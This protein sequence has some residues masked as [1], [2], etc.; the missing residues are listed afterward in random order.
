MAWDPNQPPHGFPLVSAPIRA[1]FQALDALMGPD[2]A[3]FPIRAPDGTA[4]APSYSFAS[5]P[6]TGL[7]YTNP[8]FPN[9]S[10]RNPTGGEAM[11]YGEPGTVTEL[12]INGPG[13]GGVGLSPVGVFLGTWDIVGEE[14]AYVGADSSRPLALYAGG[15]N[16]R[17]ETTGAFQPDTDNAFDLGDAT[18]RVRDLHLGRD[19]HLS[20]GAIPT[21]VAGKATLTFAT[22]PAWGTGVVVQGPDGGSARIFSSPGATE[23]ALVTN[24]GSEG[25]MEVFNYGA[26]NVALHFHAPADQVA[27]TTTD[28]TT[29][30]V[31]RLVQGVLELPER[32]ATVPTP[33]ANTVVIYAK[34][35]DHKL[36]A[37]NSAGVETALW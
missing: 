29:S 27:F 22:V 15:K 17:L 37:K 19:L 21:P 32:T 35:S 30:P 8:G 36:Y 34:A 24:N 26:G 10:L 25:Y 6:G 13:P 14:E 9:V 3:V 2:G 20:V 11:F 1:N 16:W 31:I 12:S 18:H 5:A 23:L 4:L 33:P 7:Y 28:G